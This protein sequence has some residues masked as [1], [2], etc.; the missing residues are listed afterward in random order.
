MRYRYWSAGDYLSTCIVLFEFVS[1]LEIDIMFFM[2]QGLFHIKTFE[3]KF[4]IFF[5]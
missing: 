2:S 5:A 4:Y 3:A 1:G